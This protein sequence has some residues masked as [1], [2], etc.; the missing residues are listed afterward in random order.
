MPFFSIITVTYNAAELLPGTIESVLEQTC[1]DYEYLIIDGASTDGTAE[2]VRSYGDRVHHFQS[3]P[4]RGLYDAMNKGLRAAR[5][6]FV[7]FLNAG[8]HLH[9]RQVLARIQALVTDATDVL[10]GETLVVRAD[11][12]PV[13]L[14]SEIRPQN[15]PARLTWRDM[16]HGM[17]VCHQA[18]L[19]ARTLAPEYALDN[20]AADIDWIITILKRARQVV[21]AETILVDFLEGGVS[22]QRHRESLWG[23]YAILKKH[24]GWLPNLLAHA[25]ITVRAARFR[26]LGK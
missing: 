21:N 25:W 18:F 6:R 19:P 1:D 13:G 26:F 8:D 16:R 20:L 17:V 24:F 3:E 14:F 2:L 22:K 12:S 15:L 10:Y 11:R 9:D 23:R 4:D 5:G 7:Q